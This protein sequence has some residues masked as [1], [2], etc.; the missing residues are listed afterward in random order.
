MRIH[1][2]ELAA[3]GPFPEKIFIDFEELNDAGI[4]LLNG[5]TGS[6]KSSILD[7]ICFA[8]YGH[9]PSKRPNLHSHFAAEGVEP[10]VL[11]EFTVEDQRY[12]V[13]RTPEWMRPR[14]RKGR[15]GA[16]P[17]LKEKATGSLD[18][19]NAAT[20]EWENIETQA[21]E[22]GTIMTSIIKLNRDQFSQVM[23]LPQGK[24]ASFLL[25]NSGERETLLKQLFN[26]SEYQQIQEALK[27]IAKEAEKKAEAHQQALLALKRDAAGAVERAKLGELTQLQRA[28]LTEQFGELIPE[29]LLPTQTE[30]IAEE[31]ETE[32][33]FTYLEKHL[34][35]LAVEEQN[36]QKILDAASQEYERRVGER[37][38]FETLLKNWQAHEELVAEREELAQQAETMIAL[39][40][41][42][43]KARDAQNVVHPGKVFETAQAKAQTAQASFSQAWEGYL[44]Q[45][46]LVSADTPE[47]SPEASLS[48]APGQTE[49]E[50]HTYSQKLTG[51]IRALEDLLDQ[52]KQAEAIKQKVTHH[53]TQIAALDQKLASATEKE[54]TLKQ[55]IEAE[56]AFITKN[57]D[58]ASHKVSAEHALET[59]QE[60][61]KQ[62]EILAK[63]TG[64]TAGLEQKVQATR[65]TR[66]DASSV[67]E[68]LYTLRY[69]QATLVLAQ[70]L[71][72]GAPCPVC[73]SV[74]H[75][76]PAEITETGQTVEDRHIEE[77]QAERNKAE[78]A[79]QKALSAFESHQQQI[80]ALHDA[81]V[82]PLED[83]KSKLAVAQEEL[84][85]RKK[86]LTELEARQKQLATAHKQ[87]ETH[88]GAVRTDQEQRVQEAT[89]LSA[90]QDTAAQLEEQL[91]QH[92]TERP[93]TERLELLR[94][95][96]KTLEGTQQ[97]LVRWQTAREQE[98]TAQKNLTEA[99][100]ASTFEN[101]ASARAA[102]MDNTS[103]QAAQEKLENFRAAQT[104][105]STKLAEEAQQD[106]AARISA[107]QS[108]PDA[109]DLEAY[110]GKAQ[111]LAQKNQA[112]TQAQ[113]SLHQSQQLLGATQTTY[114][115]TL[116]EAEELIIDA[117]RK[118]HLAETANGTDKD[119]TLKMTL[120]TFVLATQLAEITKAASQHLEKMT[121]GRYLLKHTDHSKGNAKAGLGI[122]VHD[123]W[124]SK[125]RAPETLS[126][127]ETF[128][129]SLALAL[130]LADVVR[131]RAGGIDI[132][133]LFV[134]EGFG[135]LDDATL[136][137]VMTTL[138]GLRERG[139]VIGL[140]SHVTEMKNRIPQQILLATSPEG[141]RLVSGAGTQGQ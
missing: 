10:Y 52:E 40:K 128:M 137:E 120:T 88:Q 45:L 48:E 109:S 2:L 68:N 17:Y 46:V 76:H 69:R 51:A 61:V 6:G 92:R 4:F 15:A 74:E 126:G 53:T 59:A 123:S 26:T 131:Q 32:D 136:E 132:D 107:G 85:H 117:Q 118:K 1:S 122:A 102:A 95:V 134:D 98:E 57:Q 23:L 44:K 111:V 140:I 54:E 62:A 139:R 70:N 38:R 104:R 115:K 19:L 100:A 39:G 94:A 71:E 108:K 43:E 75:P 101:L 7:A 12:R 77:A 31:L 114:Q 81:G 20:G 91:T 90:A 25:S 49:E 63:L 83:A 99:L 86:H 36:N 78:S 112:L 41:T 125:D 135:T 105:N 65:A 30:N 72:D 133:T 29:E 124:H 127:G 22:V 5:P 103:Y 9:T 97:T 14:R 93:F 130:G 66:E 138:D 24:F 13:R 8:L 113:G 33:F 87:L 3:Y 89:L 56:T 47:N 80:S 16:D 73:G 37:E 129:A 11:M 106:I 82:L 96:Q 119:N 58:A 116:A 35:N 60:Q 50:L 79:A 110:S 84:T 64:K 21:R 18:K 34:A 141:S 42:L 67:L 121:H 27:D 28:V 55:K